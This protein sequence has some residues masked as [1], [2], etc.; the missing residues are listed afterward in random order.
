[1]SA[2]LLFQVRNPVTLVFSY[3]QVF[4]RSLKDLVDRL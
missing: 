1:M 4:F 3:H 2:Y